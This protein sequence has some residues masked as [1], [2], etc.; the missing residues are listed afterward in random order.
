M[1]TTRPKKVTDGRKN[2][3]NRARDPTGS[4]A[5]PH[6]YPLAPHLPP[7]MPPESRLTYSLT[8]LLLTSCVTASYKRVIITSKMLTFDVLAGIYLGFVNGKKQ[9]GE[10]RFLRGLSGGSVLIVICTTSCVY[11]RYKNHLTF[12]IPGLI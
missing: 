9:K 1:V 12:I 7:V 5:Q 10:G 4:K 2:D 11:A 8:A 3:S 6:F